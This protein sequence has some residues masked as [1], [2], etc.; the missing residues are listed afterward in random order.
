MF[1]NLNQSTITNAYALMEDSKKQ[2]KI[3]AEQK[4]I[5][6]REKA[7]EGSFRNLQLNQNAEANKIGISSLRLSKI[8]VIITI[9]V[10]ISTMVIGIYSLISTKTE[11]SIQIHEL[12]VQNKRLQEQNMILITTAKALNKI[13]K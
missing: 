8:A 4:A 11:Q 5:K 7:E 9:L 6:A 2:E 1:E 3:K 12:E 10:G 13:N